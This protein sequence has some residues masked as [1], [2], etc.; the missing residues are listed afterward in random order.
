VAKVIKYGDTSSIEDSG[1]KQAPV[2]L[3]QAKVESIE[4]KNSKNTNDP[5]VEVVL[6]LVKDANGKKL[7]ENYGQLWYYAPLDP[8]ASWARRLKDL[9]TAFG[10]KDKNGNLG[11]IE[12]KMCLVRLR[13]DT[14]LNGDYRPT[15]GKVMKLQDAM[16]DEEE[17]EDE[18][19]EESDDNGLSAL[20]R[21][22]LKKYIKDNDLE[23]TIRRSMDDDD[24]REAIQELLEVQ[25]EE[26]PDDEEEDDEEEDDEEPEAEEEEDN[27]DSMSIKAIRQELSDRELDTKGSKKV[28]IARLRTDDVEEPV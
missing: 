7:K 13:E 14:D 24:I 11:A 26:E 8:D 1:F 10:L 16:E 25:D 23:V 5:M 18:E 12:G 19:E 27:Y 20:T 28:L 21:A 4:Q 3:Y 6:R 9:I 2:G 17:P 15:V 22:E